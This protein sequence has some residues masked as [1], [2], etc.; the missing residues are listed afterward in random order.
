MTD[1]SSELEAIK[2]RVD[3]LGEKL[4][5]LISYLAIQADKHGWDSIDIND[6]FVM[7][8]LKSNYNKANKLVKRSTPAAGAEASQSIAELEARRKKNPS[9]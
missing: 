7:E 6:S 1:H 8:L 5:G 3:T 4:S 9:A 2:Q